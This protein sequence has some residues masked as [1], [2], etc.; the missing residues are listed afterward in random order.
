MENHRSLFHHV[1]PAEDSFGRAGV[2]WFYPSFG[3]G[4]PSAICI[5]YQPLP[6]RRERTLETDSDIVCRPLEILVQV[7]PQ[8]LCR[9]YLR[10][11]YQGIG[12]SLTT[13]GDKK[14]LGDP[15]SFY[16]FQGARIARFS[17]R[18]SLNYEWNFGLSAGWKPYDNY[19]NSYNGAVGSRMNAYINAGVYINW[20]FSR[21]FDLIVGG[22]FTHFSNGNTK[23][24]NAGIN[25]AGAK[26][27]LVYNFN[28]T[29]EDL[30]KSLYQPVTTRFPRHISYDVVL[31]G[32]WRRKGVWVGE[33]QIASPNAYPVAGFNFAPM[34]NLGYKFRVGAS[35][36]GVYDGS[37]NV[38]RED[39][40]VEYGSSSSKRE[41]LKPGIQHQLALGL[42]GRAEYVMPYFTIGVGMGAN[43]LSR[44]DMRGFYQILALK[45][46][47]TRSSFLHIGYN[48]QNFQTP[49][50]LMLG[51]GFRFHNKYPK[52]RH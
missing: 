45:I 43:V 4:S 32:S 13:F 42:S 26:I 10:W 16:V 12:V 7:S 27:G 14:Q 51:L 41:F 44:G 50:Y 31:F 28:R 48:L 25:T 21:Y 1:L 6:A 36:D 33:K 9:P 22:D 30:S 46:A 37:A 18:A 39:V 2:F 47:V 40:I 17:P 49:N 35:L 8:Y 5:S 23:F 20:A 52:V 34:Y 3:N 11:S 29:E 24:P 38:Y 19:Y 15:F